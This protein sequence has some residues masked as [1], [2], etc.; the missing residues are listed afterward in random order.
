V[1]SELKIKM[2]LLKT[3]FVPSFP[4]T[5]FGRKGHNQVEHKHKRIR[6]LC[7]IEISKPHSLCCYVGVQN[8]KKTLGNKVRIAMHYRFLKTGSRVY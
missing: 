4:T 8:R 6:V 1:L 7:G 5:C 3:K 2:Y